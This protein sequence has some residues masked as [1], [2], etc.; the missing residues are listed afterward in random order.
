MSSAIHE[1]ENRPLPAVDRI[2]E[3]NQGTFRS[4]FNRVPF[5]LHHNLEEH[6]LLQM[7]PLTELARSLAAR[8]GEVYIDVGAGRVEQ[9][10]NETP[11]ASEPVDEV[12]AGISAAKAWVVLRRAELD[13]RYAALL[14]RCMSELRDLNGGSWHHRVRVQQNAIIFITSPCRIST[15]HID[16]ECNFILQI[17][18]EKVIYVFDQNDREVLPEQELERFWAVDNNAATYK[19]QYQSRA[20][21]FHLGP[22]DGVHVPVNAPHWVQNGDDSSITLSIN[23]QFSDSY[24]ANLYRANYYLRKCGINPTPPGRSR[25]RDIVKTTAIQGARLVIKPLRGLRI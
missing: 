1:R 20:R 14:S 7:T 2:I 10:W 21:A 16:R 13:A 12:L 24:K 6:P 17:R 3:V 4:K 15:Y 23:F 25:I 19:P 9:R 22:G 11:R 5:A 8:P 18:G